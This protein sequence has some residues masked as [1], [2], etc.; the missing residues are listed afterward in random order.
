MI[1]EH[2]EL[3]CG[4]L[5]KDTLGNKAGSLMHA[6]VMEQGHEVGSSILTSILLVCAAVYHY[7]ILLMDTTVYY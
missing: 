2:G 5:S 7:S 1:I 6:V 3:L 4:I